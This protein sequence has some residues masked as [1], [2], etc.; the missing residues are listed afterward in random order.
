MLS[1]LYIDEAVKHY[2]AVGAVRE[3]LASVPVSVVPDA[4]RLYD[5]LSAMPDPIAAGKRVLFLTRNKGPFL[6]ECPGT[7]S[8]ICC[9]YQIL[10]IGTYCTMDCAYCI[11]QAYFHPPVLQYFVNQERLFEE[12]DDVV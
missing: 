9:G 5:A 11:L 7:K 8:Y 10:H 6:K 3:A 4:A 2:P 1:R 12:L